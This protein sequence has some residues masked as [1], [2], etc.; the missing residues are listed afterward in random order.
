MHWPGIEGSMEPKRITSLIEVASTSSVQVHV[1]LVNETTTKQMD[2]RTHVDACMADD[3]AKPRIHQTVAQAVVS[4]V[5]FVKTVALQCM[6]T[7]FFP[8]FHENYTDRKLLP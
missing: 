4:T 2:N 5:F 1:E 8:D 7:K 3:A 6:P